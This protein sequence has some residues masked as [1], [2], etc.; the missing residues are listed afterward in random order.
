M[1]ELHIDLSSSSQI[2]DE[3]FIE[4]FEALNAIAPTATKL[5]LTLRKCGGLTDKA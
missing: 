1:K 4:L 3:G 5:S 2:K